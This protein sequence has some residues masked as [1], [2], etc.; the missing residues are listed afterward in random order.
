[1]SFEKDF[2]RIMAEPVNREVLTVEQYQNQQR[3]DAYR[4][5]CA[6]HRL[7]TYKHNGETKYAVGATETEARQRMLIATGGDDPEILSIGPVEAKA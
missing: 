7:I 3:I 2:Q 4:E 1:M 5:R 6:R